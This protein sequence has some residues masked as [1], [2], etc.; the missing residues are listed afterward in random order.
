MKYKAGYL[1]QLA[2]DYRVKIPI[3]R[4][5]GKKIRQ[6]FIKLTVTGILTLKKGYA[7]DGPSGPAIDTDNFMRGSLVH[8]AL[9]QLMRKQRLDG[10]TWR[11]QADRI[12]Q[13]MCIEDGMWRVR[14]WWVYKSVSMFGASAADPA[15]EKEILIAP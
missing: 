7:W 8:D 14:A 15:N 1:Y 12:L 11:D 13:Q 5:K 4:Y 10:D 2:E 3:R 9:Y 6:G